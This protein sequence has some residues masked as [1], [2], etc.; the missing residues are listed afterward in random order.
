MVEV[1]SNALAF[2]LFKEL[3]VGTILELHGSIESKEPEQF[4]H[5]ED[6]SDAAGN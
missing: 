2:K 1:P 6:H 4:L 3:E 5:D